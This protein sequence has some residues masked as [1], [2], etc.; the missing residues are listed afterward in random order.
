MKDMMVCLVV[1]VGG[2]IGQ[3]AIGAVPSILMSL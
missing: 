3:F 2:L 1:A